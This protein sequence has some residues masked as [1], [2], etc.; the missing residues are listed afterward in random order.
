LIPAASPHSSRRARAKLIMNKAVELASAFRSR[1]ETVPR[2]FRAPGRVN[3]IGEH[4]DYN[5]GFV[6]PAAI[7]LATYAA[8]APRA[9]RHLVV[10]SRA[11]SETLDFSLDDPAPAARG[12]WGDY[13]R[14]VALELR[15]IM[16]LTGADVMLDGNLPFGAGLSS[17]AALEVA[18]GFALA[19]NAGASIDPVKLALL[20][21]RAENNF[22]GLRCGIMDQY[23]SCCGKEGCAVLL[24]CR[25]LV[26]RAAP[27]AP[28]VK[29]VICDTMIRHE[30]AS[31][32]YNKRRDEC[33]QA[34]SI[35]AAAIPGVKALRDVSC[36]QFERHGALLPETLRRRARHVVTENERTLQAAAALEAQDMEKCGSLMND[37]HRSLSV[38]Y[39]V[40]CR[41]ADLMAKLAQEVPGA[42]GARMTGGGFGGCVVGLVKTGDVEPF[43]NIVG[44][45]YR[46]A[47]SLTPR[48]FCTSPSAGVGEV[49]FEV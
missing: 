37:S 8:I 40:S 48:I 10:H 19:T 36:E 12:N 5:D 47:T 16:P 18:F 33:A 44:E 38:D 4:T 14:G 13:L 46:K 23:I 6:L 17:S 3:V 15:Q 2:I 26:A 27:I 25:D 21:Q 42:L 49:S 31:S 34:V 45:G 28:S 39:E 24:D 29:L 9:D 7:D 43:M 20:C 32:A 1:F 11:F 30:L 35:L 41:E 22:V